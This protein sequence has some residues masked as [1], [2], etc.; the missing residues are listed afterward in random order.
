MNSSS[1]GKAR[2]RV[3]KKLVFL[4]VFALV[5]LAYVA[6]PVFAACGGGKAAAAGGNAA[7]ASKQQQRQNRANNNNNNADNNNADNNNANNNNKANNNNNKAN[8]NNNKANNNNNKA[9][10]NNNK[11]N[12]NNNKANNKNKSKGKGK[13]KGKGNKNKGKGNGNGNAV[14]ASTRQGGGKLS[15]S[16]RQIIAQ[17][18][19]D[20][21]SSLQLVNLNGRSLNPSSINKKGQQFKIKLGGNTLDAVSLG[22]SL[23]QVILPDRQTTT[24]SLRNL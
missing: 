7:A 18:Q 21:L 8:N 2:T 14:S 23:V 1:L 19:N 10:N 12:N 16:D 6:T 3:V 24:L 22:N 13:G 11:A 5:A 15:S 4:F 9:N 20:S 17:L